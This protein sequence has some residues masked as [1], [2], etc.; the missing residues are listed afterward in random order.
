MR[1]IDELPLIILAASQAVGKT[2]IRN[3]EELRF[4]ESDRISSMVEM[5]KR[6]NISINEFDDGM[7]VYG[8]IIEGN[9]INS[10]GDHRVA[11]TALLASLVSR[12]DIIV[13]DTVNIDTSFPDFINIANNIGMDI[14]VYD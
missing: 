12:E 5:M 14:K 9:T 2:S 1:S 4:K 7:E 13:Q 10:F 6:F 11:M 3:A 8:G